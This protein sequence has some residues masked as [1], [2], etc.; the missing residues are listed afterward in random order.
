VVAQG[1]DQIV[2]EL[3]IALPGVAQQVQTGLLRLEATQ[4]VDGVEVYAWV[5]RCTKLC[6][7]SRLP[8]AQSR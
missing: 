2:G 3:P 4:V 7:N 1:V 8:S 6:S 5:S